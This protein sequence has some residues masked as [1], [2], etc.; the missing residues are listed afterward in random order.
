M[1]DAIFG[2]KKALE[3]PEPEGQ[4]KVSVKIPAGVRSGSVIRLRAKNMP[5]EDLVL[6][7]RVA[8]HP[9]LT[10]QARGLVA[11]IPITIQEAIVG[12]HISVPTLD[13][14]VSIKIPPGSQSGSELRLKNRGLTLKDGT[15]GDL[16]VRLMIR[17]P[18]TADAV[19]LKE[20]ASELDAYYSNNVR[21]GLPKHLVE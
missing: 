2:V 13:E 20:K 6:I 14:A 21:Q 4:R 10:I 12:A 8:A 17:V 3:I 11:E 1:H 5:N 7:V 19:G 15:R 18:E 9:F 16:F